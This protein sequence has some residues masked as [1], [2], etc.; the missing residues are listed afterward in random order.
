MCVD[1]H[2][3]SYIRDQMHTFPLT[4]AEEPVLYEEK[5]QSIDTRF[6]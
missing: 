3:G 5:H 1:D 4:L 6:K 2:E